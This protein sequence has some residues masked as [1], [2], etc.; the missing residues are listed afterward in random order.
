MMI[1]TAIIS[2]PINWVKVWLMA[3]TFFVAVYLVSNLIETERTSS[4]TA[5]S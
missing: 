5:S 4:G 2:N 1:N 3:T